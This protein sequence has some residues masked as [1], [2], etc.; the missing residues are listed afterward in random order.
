MPEV[1][2]KTMMYSA[3][4]SIYL[5]IERRL[6]HLKGL[7]PTFS[8]RRAVAAK[9]RRQGGR[10]QRVVRPPRIADE[11]FKNHSALPSLFDAGPASVLKQS[12]K[13]SKGVQA[14]ARDLADG[15]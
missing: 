5:P 9:P 6:V 13:G 7:T 15:Q 2:A 12:Q 11:L 1:S 4:P 3:G 14:V 10:L 8:R